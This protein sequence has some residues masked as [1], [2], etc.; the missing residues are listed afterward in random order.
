MAKM[1]SYLANAVQDKTKFKTLLTV[2]QSIAATK[3]KLNFETIQTCEHNFN[4]IIL[5]SDFSLD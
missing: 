5:L 1:Q 2:N 3:Y 4:L